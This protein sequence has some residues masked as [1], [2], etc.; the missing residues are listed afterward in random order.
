MT[1]NPD[2]EMTIDYIELGLTK[3]TEDDVRVLVLP[4]S[5]EAKEA[6]AERLAPLIDPLCWEVSCNPPKDARVPWFDYRPECRERARAVLA[7]LAKRG[8][9]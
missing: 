1:P 3:F 6:M 8:K 7:A 2:M 5:K 9:R 4:W